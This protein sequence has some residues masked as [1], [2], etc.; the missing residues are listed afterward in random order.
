MV[1]LFNKAAIVPDWLE[2]VDCV[3]YSI[4]ISGYE[5]LAGTTIDRASAETAE[6]RDLVVRKDLPVEAGGW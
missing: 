1:S 2:W 4:I 6:I 3:F 5:M